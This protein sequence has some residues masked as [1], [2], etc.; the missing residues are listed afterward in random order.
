MRQRWGV[1]QALIG[2]P[3]L[4]ILDEPTAGLDPSERNRFHELLFGLGEQAA[5]I[6][7]THIV[8]D[9]ADL[10]GRVA[11]LAGGRVLVE[12]A[13]DE[14]SGLLEGKVWRG[15]AED[16]Q[17]SDCAVLSRG[18]SR[19]QRIARVLAGER[20]GPSFEPTSVTLEDTYFAALLSAPE[21]RR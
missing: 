8:E 4:V 9:V 1:A 5:V 16:C 2:H 14:L 10:C 11:V 12:G 19:G 15:P 21:T 13:P 6:L 18:L 20:P 3:D 7:S 17:T